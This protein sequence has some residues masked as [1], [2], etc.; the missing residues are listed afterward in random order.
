MVERLEK[1]SGLQIA[2]AFAALSIAYFHSWHVTMPFPPDTAHPIP[3]LKDYGW[4]AVD[5]FF[6]ISGFVICLVVTK[7]GFKPLQFLIRRAFRLYPLWIVTSIAMAYLFKKYLGWPPNATIGF[8]AYS[9]TLLPTDG[10]PFY[11]LGWTLQHELAFY[12][13]AAL[14]APRFGLVGLITFLSAGF[15]MDHLVTLPWYL[16]QYAFYY[17]NFL[18]GVGAFLVYP[19]LKRL[20][21][22]AP[23]AVALG[24]LYLFT[25]TM[26]RIAFPVGLF[27]MLIA[28]VNIRLNPESI[29]ERTGV[30]LGDASYS[31]YLIHPLV[32]YF[33]YAK[34]QPPLPPIWSQELLRFGSIAIVCLLAIASWK[35]F[36][37][38]MI[39]VGIRITSQ[40]RK[41]VVQ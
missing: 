41:P 6:A 26:G 40:Q 28:F 38:R 21:F 37:T 34:L 7:P 25:Q 17:P 5:L 14:I 20:G 23:L 29:W 31:I 30:L 8:V 35:L 27:F 19:H 2:R 1:L 15:I 39:S 4:I 9:F 3:L 32:F 22:L 24:L 11:D 10:Y 18:A 36:E 16:H 13:L 33:V 12:V